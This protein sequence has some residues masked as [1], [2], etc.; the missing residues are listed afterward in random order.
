MK[1]LIIALILLLPSFVCAENMIVMGWDGAGYNNVERLLNEG[2]LPNLQNFLNSGGMM[3]P[4]IEFAHY[5]STVPYWAEIFTGLGFDQTG[6]MGNDK[7][8]SPNPI[9]LTFYEGVGY[10]GLFKWLNLIR[11]ED[12]ILYDI[13]LKGYKIGWFVSKKNL[14]NSKDYSAFRNIALMADV[15]LHK[16]A[17]CDT[18]I[19]S[20]GNKTLEFISQNPNYFIFL[21]VDPDWYGHAYGENSSRYE[22]EFIRADDWLGRILSVIDENTK[23]I[24]IADHG[25]DEGTNHHANAPDAWMATNLP[26]HPAYIL[27][28]DQRAFPLSRD[29]ADTILTFYGVDP[30]TKTLQHRGKSLLR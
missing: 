20:L 12:T 16:A 27:Q 9:V 10:S 8:I 24:V 15:Y 22:E 1:K 7:Y 5:T 6:V 2:K 4:R 28:E 17:G 30:K 3:I 25:F 19:D 11:Y 21:H 18:Y 29:V 14:N 23:V 13:Q 26:I